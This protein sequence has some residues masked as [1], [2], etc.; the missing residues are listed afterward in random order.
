[1]DNLTE[2]QIQLRG[3]A[4]SHVLNDD[5]M[6]DALKHLNSAME[7]EVLTTN[8]ADVERREAAFSAYNGLR[9][10]LKTLH[11]WRDQAKVSRQIEKENQNA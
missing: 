3:D 6:K 2:G 9:E 11:T 4:A 5:T 8:L 1:M 10:L 7:K